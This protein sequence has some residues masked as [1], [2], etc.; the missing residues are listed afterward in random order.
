[1]GGFDARIAASASKRKPY[2]IYTAHGFHFF[3]GA[4]LKNWLL[5]YPV[6]YLLAKKTDC[7]ITINN[8]DLQVAGKLPVKGKDSIFYIHGVGVDD[9]RFFPRPELY[10]KKRAEL[11][12]PEG[13][14]HIV[15]AAELNDNKNLAVVIR[16]VAELRREDILYSICGEG[17]ERK[18]LESL[19]TDLGLERNVRLLGYRN[20]MEEV[21][22]SADA[23]AFPSKREGLGVAAVEALLSGVP[24]ICADN[25][26]TREYAVHGKNSIVCRT[27]KVSEYSS[28]IEKLYSDTEY[29]NR[30]S[31]S[32]KE[33]AGAF[34][35]GET[36]K[37]MRPIYE[38]ALAVSGQ[39]HVE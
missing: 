25:R 19:I 31:E 10:E 4:P 14:F 29:R 7:I 17:P 32:C 37:I 6:E 24:L 38:R 3:K 15:S 20:D 27:G 5:F 30:L 22:A 8:E 39:R 23:F 21:L 12:V 18:K 26:G 28:A 33:S 16:A 34:V 36:A 9:N 13:A 11:G 1:M 35:T 2:V